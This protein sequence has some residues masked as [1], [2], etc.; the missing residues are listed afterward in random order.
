MVG[1]EVQELGQVGMPTRLQVPQR[2]VQHGRRY[3][4]YRREL[5]VQVARATN[6]QQVLALH[7]RPPHQLTETRNAAG[8]PQNAQHN[9]PRRADFAVEQLGHVRLGFNGQQVD[10]DRFGEVGG[11]LLQA[12]VQREQVGVG[13]GEEGN[14][15]GQH[16]GRRGAGGRF[17]PVPAVELEHVFGQLGGGREVGIGDHQTV[18]VVEDGQHLPVAV[19]GVKPGGAPVKEQRHHVG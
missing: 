2:L 16:G 6:H 7:L 12:A 3:C 10:A 9:H 18:E 4:R 1:Q 15:L 19:D 8:P 5:R 17:G 13:V 14:A 11:Q